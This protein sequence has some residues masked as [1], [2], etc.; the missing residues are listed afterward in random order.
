MKCR[1]LYS[2]TTLLTSDDGLDPVDRRIRVKMKFYQNYQLKLMKIFN[3][4]LGNHKASRL[5]IDN[6]KE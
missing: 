5:Q 3:F 2:Q 6:E 1:L 4:P